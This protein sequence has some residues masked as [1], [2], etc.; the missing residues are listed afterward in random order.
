M[1]NFSTT[2]CPVCRAHCCIRLLALADRLEHCLR[3]GLD[4]RQFG[5]DAVGIVLPISMASLSLLDILYD[6][7]I[8]HRPLLRQRRRFCTGGYECRKRLRFGPRDMH[9]HPVEDPEGILGCV[10][11]KEAPGNRALLRIAQ[12]LAD[13]G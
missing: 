1:W 3:L 11:Y 12:A 8:R 13:E 9:R 6:M 2:S 10:V 7:Q 5:N 4:L